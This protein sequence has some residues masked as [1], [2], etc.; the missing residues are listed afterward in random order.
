MYLN[1]IEV[2]AL[3]MTGSRCSVM[4]E[5]SF[6]LLTPFLSRVSRWWAKMAV[7]HLWGEGEEVD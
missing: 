5:L 4:T 6:S 7:A 1:I 3:G 2:L